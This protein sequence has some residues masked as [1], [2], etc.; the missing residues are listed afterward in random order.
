[1]VFASK[2]IRLLQQVR[3]ELMA[4]FS[5]LLWLLEKDASLYEKVR[6][7]LKFSLPQGR[8]KVGLKLVKPGID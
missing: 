3:R 8:G 5:Y 7:V 1:M 4:G 6:R 2:G